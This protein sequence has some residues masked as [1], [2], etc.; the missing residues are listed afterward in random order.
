MVLSTRELGV[1]LSPSVYSIPFKK[2]FKSVSVLAI[3]SG[4]GYDGARLFQDSSYRAALSH[5]RR[6]KPLWARSQSTSFFLKKKA[7]EFDLYA[8][9]TDTEILDSELLYH[10]GRRSW[11]CGDDSTRVAYPRTLTRTLPLPAGSAYPRRRRRQLYPLQ[12]PIVRDRPFVRFTRPPLIIFTK[13]K[14]DVIHRSYSSF[15]ELSGIQ[16]GAY[17]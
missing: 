8:L 2:R 4:H 13:K 14:V 3:I 16:H 1:S 7:F 17:I 12:I 15:V 9:G 5:S 11:G 10:A 6:R